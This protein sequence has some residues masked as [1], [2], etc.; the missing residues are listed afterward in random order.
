MKPD[1]EPQ[2]A[3][4]PRDKD[5]RI[6][7][8]V[9][10]T[11]AVL[12]VAFVVLSLVFREN[13]SQVFIA[14]KDAVTQTAGWFFII[15]VNVFLAVCVFLL[16]SD[17]GNIRLGGEAAKPDYSY[18]TWLAMLFSAGMG[19]G[20]VF[21]SVAEPLYHFTSP[22]LEGIEGGSPQAANMAMA[23]TYFHWGL[24]A[25][26][27]YALMGMALAYYAYNKGL[28]LTIRSTLHPLLG[29]KIDGPLGNT[30]DIIASVA[31]LF[32]VATSL[33]L[34]V[35]QINAGLEHTFGLN[36]SP[37]VQVVLIA[38]ITAI[39]TISVVTGLD[40]GIRRLSETNMV[41]A[42]LLLLVVFIV[43]P[44]IGFLDGLV[45]NLG[46][47]VRHFIF[48]SSWTDTYQASGWRQG[49]TVF[50]WAW[51][52]AWSP[53]VGMFIAR[54][55]RGRTLREFTLT[56]LLVPTL[57]TFLWLS[58]FGNAGLLVSLSG[59]TAVM[60]AV[61]ANTA[62]ALFALF[63]QYSLAG[64]P[65][66]TVLSVVGIL[67]IVLF[68]VT[69]SDSGS[70]VIDTITAGGHTNPPVAQRVFWATMEG[71]VAAVLLYV[72]GKQALEALQTASVVTG[73]PFAI[74]L[75]IIAYSL[76]LDLYRQRGS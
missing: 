14:T 30:V 20:L 69:S 73:L 64:L 37:E 4:F 15:A 8:T 36:N 5:T 74:V 75:L 42:F 67:V 22:P 6:H 68:F 23:V 19:I 33:G 50:Y 2:S 21:W 66:G 51:W 60:D 12:V 54:I 55:S 58:V 63:E 71:M 70:L 40:K 25:W 31:T 17:K 41:L 10:L 39:A 52:I 13:A 46:A 57:M 62:M 24:H 49:W 48:L 56:V 26:G 53:F 38:I 47:Y 9:F 28:P 59:D 34:G 7:P 27:I 18:T 61:N 76:L 16:F 11:S 44:T 72:G 65:L 1:N 43:G 29:D 35:K 3:S 32:G 45:Q